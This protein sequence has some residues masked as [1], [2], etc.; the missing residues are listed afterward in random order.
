LHLVDGQL[1]IWHNPQT[2]ITL[3]GTSKPE[4]CQRIWERCEP[5]Q[6]NR[7]KIIPELRAENRILDH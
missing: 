3:M 4:Y 5:D 1:E 2:L 7:L 6:E